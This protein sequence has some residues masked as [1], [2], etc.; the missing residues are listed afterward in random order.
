LYEFI[1]KGRDRICQALRHTRRRLVT[2]SVTSNPTA[3]S[4]P[5]HQMTESFPW[6]EAPR[7]LIRD[8][9]RPFSRAYTLGIRAMRIHDHFTPHSPWQNGHLERLVRS[10]RQQMSHQVVVFGESHLRGILRAYASY[11][12]QVRTRLSLNKDASD[13]RQAQKIGRRRS[14]TNLG[15]VASSLRHGLSFDFAKAAGGTG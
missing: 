11:Y 12:D 7:H 3:D 14:V 1:W 5:R 2:I 9:D 8:C 15:R 6:D 10:I 13:F 4:I